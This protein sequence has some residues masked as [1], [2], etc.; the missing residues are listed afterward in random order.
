MIPFKPK[1]D[2][3]SKGE[4]EPSLLALLKMCMPCPMCWQ[5]DE[6]HLATLYVASPE[7]D[8]NT[9]LG[10]RVECCRC[11]PFED[12]DQPFEAIGP[13]RK[14]PGDAVA[15]WNTLSSAAHLVHRVLVWSMIQENEDGAL[16]DETQDAINALPAAL[17]TY[18]AIKALCGTYK[19]SYAPR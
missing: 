13:P 16:G 3:A 11:V 15:A 2:K 6:L 4:R 12:A 10:H 5:T 9:V 18:A 7:S 17:K 8:E 19:L 1:N 14:Q